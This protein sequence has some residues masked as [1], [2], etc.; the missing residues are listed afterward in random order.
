MAHC[1]DIPVFVSDYPKDLKPFYARINDD[2][3]TVGGKLRSSV[4]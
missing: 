4:N 2:G 3:C 1:G